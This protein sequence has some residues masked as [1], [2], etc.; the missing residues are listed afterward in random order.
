MDYLDEER[1]LRSEQMRVD[2]GIGDGDGPG[3]EGRSWIALHTINQ[4]RSARSGLFS[5]RAWLA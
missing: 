3:E 4:C 2:G 5:H 1:R